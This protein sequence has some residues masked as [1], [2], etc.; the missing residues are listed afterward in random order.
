VI[1]CYITDRHSLKG[2]LVGKIN[3]AI[4]A[5]VDYVQIREKD[6]PAR[7][8]EGLV[9]RIKRQQLTTKFPAPR[10]LLNTRV[11]VAMATGLDGV[12]LPSAEISPKEVREIW[13]VSALPNIG[14]SCHS[15]EEVKVAAAHGADFAVFGPVFEKG[16]AAPQGLNRLR[17]VCGLGIPVLALGGVTVENARPCLAV[18]AAGVAGIRLFQ[19]NNIAATV[20]ALR[21]IRP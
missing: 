8:L 3:D 16:D 17:E 2:D 10:I 21:A 14:V 19:D 20:N 11:D 5:G 6:L 12:H 9:S 13:H 7:S 18:G 4:A 1:L 15:R